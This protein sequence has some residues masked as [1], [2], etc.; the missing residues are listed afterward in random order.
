[1]SGYNRLNIEEIDLNINHY[2]ESTVNLKQYS[3][4]I[5]NK[6]MKIDSGTLNLF[7]NNARSIMKDDRLDE[8][9]I[10]L[11]TIGNPFHILVFTETWLSDKNKDLCQFDGYVPLHLLRPTDNQYDFKTWKVEYLY[12]SKNK[13]N[14]N[15]DNLFLISPSIECIFIELNFNN[16]KF[17]IGCVYQVPNTDVKTFCKS[18]DDLIE[19]HRSHNIILLGDYNIC[20]QQKKTVTKLNYRTQCSQ[21]VYT[22]QFLHPQQLH[23]V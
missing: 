19:P 3:I 6:D 10:L 9:N 18:I 4:D 13:L 1:M 20:L 14:L 8:Y 22:R 15:R 21:V 23:M 2:N 17:L 11:N 5:F 7:H 12:L 16:K